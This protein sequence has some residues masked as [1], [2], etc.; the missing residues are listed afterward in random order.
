MKNYKRQFGDDLCAGDKRLKYKW[1]WCRSGSGIPLSLI[2]KWTHFQCAAAA[3]NKHWELES[4]QWHSDS[5]VYYEGTVHYIGEEIASTGRGDEEGKYKT[6]LDAQIAA[7]K[8][9]VTWIKEQHEL[10]V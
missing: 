3:V 4:I 6:R 10:I 5:G 9:L 7:E 1:E 8:L 2:A